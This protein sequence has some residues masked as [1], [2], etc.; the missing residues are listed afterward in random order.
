MNTLIVPMDP[1]VTCR[2]YV[3]IAQNIINPSLIKPNAARCTYTGRL[4]IKCPMKKLFFNI[5]R[6]F[7]FTN[8]RYLV[9]NISSSYAFYFIKFEHLIPEIWCIYWPGW[10]LFSIFSTVKQALASLWQWTAAA[11][12]WELT[13]SSHVALMFTFYRVSQ[14]KTERW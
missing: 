3:R 1:S 12:N 4:K 14:K 9:S 7:G 2:N 6:K 13:L 10:R 5:S 11:V 8:V